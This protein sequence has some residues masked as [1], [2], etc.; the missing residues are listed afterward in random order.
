MI[1]RNTEILLELTKGV[2]D[3]RSFK[4]MVDA[5]YNLTAHRLPFTRLNI[6]SFCHEEGSWRR[7]ARRDRD[8][9]PVMAKVE[10]GELSE[11]YL[12][13]AKDY[14]H[15][16]LLIADYWDDPVSK[17][18][19]NYTEEGLRSG[20]HVYLQQ[21][22][23]VVG[24][25]SVQHTDPGSYSES[26][27]EF[28]YELGRTLASSMEDLRVYEEFPQGSKTKRGE[29]K[30]ITRRSQILPEDGNDDGIVGASPRMKHLRSIIK[31]VAKTETTVL[32]LGETGTGKALAAEAI[33]RRSIR[34]EK[35]F[36]TVNCAGFAPEL[37]ASELFGHEAGAFTGASKTHKG[38]FEVA[39]G[40]TLFLD[41]IGDISPETQV[42]LLRVLES[43][44]FERVGSSKS[45]TTDVRIIAA[46]HRNLEEMVAKGTFRADLRF[47]LNAFPVI[48]PPLRERGDDIVELAN[49]FAAHSKSGNATSPPTYST[50]AIQAFRRY[51]WYGNVRELRN[52]IER[53]MI[54]SDSGRIDLHQLPLEIAYYESITTITPAYATITNASK[55]LQVPTHVTSLTSAA[56]E[57]S[58]AII[59][60]EDV[61][62]DHILKALAKC[63]GKVSGMGG[64]AELLD[65]KP[66]TLESKMRKLRI[67]RVWK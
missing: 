45:I 62:R 48:I 64:A 6:E 2:S 3:Q 49:F 10:Y 42:R 19:P 22:G 1:V 21:S 15:K 32:L 50:E 20:I 47:R 66:K 58:T 31:K 55:P 34:H 38:R 12:R 7:V 24:V 67:R 59:P 36:I 33:H 11:P 57:S 23:C 30:I 18:L 13:L 16:P 52:V 63:Q 25:Y 54:L 39:D 41:E 4:R 29:S 46:T 65:I 35:P 8:G 61:V 51:P 60:L 14:S 17:V 9:R 56:A 28:L 53:A 40:G 27:G 5:L 26:D 43:G 44:T 37:V